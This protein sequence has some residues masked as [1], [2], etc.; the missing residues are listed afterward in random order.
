MKFPE[1]PDDFNVDGLV[2]SWL[3]AAKEVRVLRM[4]TL[5]ESPPNPESLS[6]V[7]E[8]NMQINLLDELTSQCDEGILSKGVAAI[9]ITS[10][11]IDLSALTPVTITRKEFECAADMMV[12]LGGVSLEEAKEI[13]MDLPGGII[14]SDEADTEKSEGEVSTPELEWK[15]K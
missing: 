10:I 2:A 4:N 6:K 15:F 8:L 3:M 1:P 14:I 12:S 11:P 13:M 5:M 7:I 9:G